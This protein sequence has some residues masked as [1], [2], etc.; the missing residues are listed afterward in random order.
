VSPQTTGSCKLVIKIANVIS[1]QSD[2]NPLVS[3]HVLV[4]AFYNWSSHFNI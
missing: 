1:E 2:Q 3:F 4:W